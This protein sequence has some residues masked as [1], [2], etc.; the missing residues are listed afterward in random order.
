M[1]NCSVMQRDVDA[2][3]IV[4]QTYTSKYE[5]EENAM[6][7]AVARSGEMKMF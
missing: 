7:G 2:T 5:D 1:H 6:G 3:F 4:G